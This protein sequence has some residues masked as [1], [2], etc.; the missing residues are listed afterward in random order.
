M[1]KCFDDIIY[2]GSLAGCLAAVRRRREGRRVALVERRGF[3]GCDLTGTLRMDADF[4]ETSGKQAKDPAK[5]ELLALLG[6]EALERNTVLEEGVG[7]KRWGMLEIGEIK[8]RLLDWVEENGVEVFFCLEPCAILCDSVKHGAAGLLLGS[9]W[10]YFLLEGDCLM[11]ADGTRP[12]KRMLFGG[13]WLHETEAFMVLRLEGAWKESGIPDKAGLAEIAD[14]LNQRWP[15]LTGEETR[16]AEAI[17]Y[18]IFCRENVSYLEVSYPVQAEENMGSMYQK[19]QEA[20]LHCFTLLKK[21]YPSAGLRMVLLAYEPFVGKGT[22]A[23]QLEEEPYP[24]KQ[25]D[26]AK[27]PAEQCGDM[28]F[29][30]RDVRIPFSEFEKKEWEPWEEPL[31]LQK[32]AH[33]GEL[34]LPFLGR[35]EVVLAVGGT[36]G[37]AAAVAAARE[38]AKTAVVEYH[39]GFGGTQT[40]GGIPGYYFGYRDGFASQQKTCMESRGVEPSEAGRLL[41]CTHSMQMEGVEVYN[42]ATVCGV[43]KE[44]EQ[45]TGMEIVQDGRWGLLCQKVAID[46]TGD[47]DIVAFAEVPCRLGAAENGNVQDCGMQHYGGYGYNLD[48]I[49]QDEYGEVLRGIRMGH[50][51]GGGIDFSP[52]LTPRE[53]RLFAGEAAMSMKDILLG[54]SYADTI[55]LVYTDNDPHGTMSSLLS[56]MGM[57]PY[58]GEGIRIEIPY[59]CCIPKGVKGLLAASKSISAE[60]DAA[61]YLRMAADIQNR[62]YAIGAAGG[63]A[64]L[65][66][67]DVRQIPMGQLQSKLRHMQILDGKAGKAEK[68]Q[69]DVKSLMVGA[70]EEKRVCFGKILCLP[71]KRAVPMLKKELEGAAD[72]L[73]LGIALAW[74]GERDS[75]PLLKARFQKLVQEEDP[76]SYDDRNLQKPGNNLGG[77]LEET[78]DYWRINQLLTVFALLGEKDIKADVIRLLERFRAGGAA[79]RRE[80]L[81]VSRRWDLHRIPHFD[82]LRAL[83][84]YIGCVPGAEYGQALERL[85]QRE[86]L[87]GFLGREAA[88]D[89]HNREAEDRCVGRQY[90]SA[91]MELSIGETLAK[92]K[93]AAGKEILK[94]GME[95]VHSIL[96]R[97][98][99]DFCFLQKSLDSPAK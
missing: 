47:G 43:V 89:F 68:T 30:N 37:T 42:G 7:L 26:G 70:K 31:P 76:A 80:S 56:Y 5:Q 71:K 74:F 81:Y 88:Y 29:C 28:Y 24:L 72:N 25:S 20:L 78:C 52:V 27:S 36:A 12:L 39:Y 64:A 97:R 33:T 54:K 58:H 62:G 79:V 50:R 48:A 85:A 18:R 8:R 9:K 32:L 67:C 13:T 55:A 34:P 21:A 63:M 90:Q 94:R 98:A 6:G 22:L 46:A 75:L 44:N 59:R 77:I 51:L 10:G 60:Q 17:A 87:L 1:D 61:A 2:G 14:R 23:E 40:Y 84:F 96:R 82:R 92:C 16:E 4:W 66:D 19:G 57:T 15:G 41:W 35:H 95:D 45:V 53:G 69:N 91:C 86:N 93:N 83:L 65:A 11:D 49:C 3:L 73:G 99:Y 38:G